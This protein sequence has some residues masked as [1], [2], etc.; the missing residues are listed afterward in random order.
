MRAL[1]LITA[2]SEGLTEE[3][4]GIWNSLG[5]VDSQRLPFDAFSYSV[6]LT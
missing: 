1:G 4:Q 6:G 3:E 2:T 5:S